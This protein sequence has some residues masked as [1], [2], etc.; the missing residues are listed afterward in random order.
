MIN[1]VTN[2]KDSLKKLDKDT[3]MCILEL[4]K[5]I[6]DKFKTLLAIKPQSVSPDITNLKKDLTD[7][8]DG[9]KDHVRGRNKAVME[10][11]KEL[12]NWVRRYIVDFA[13]V[14]FDDIEEVDYNE[15][16]LMSRLVP[17]PRFKQQWKKL[18][19]ITKSIWGDDWAR[20]VREDVF[21]AYL[22]NLSEQIIAMQI[23]YRDGDFNTMM[24]YYNRANKSMK[25][26]KHFLLSV[27]PKITNKYPGSS[28][29]DVLLSENCM[30]ILKM[31]EKTETDIEKL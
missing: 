5:K 25:M 1:G 15:E 9:V 6:D 21:V 23:C 11:V 26:L 7:R 28:E 31:A 29:V 16:K 20:K 13:V 19:E 14:G 8:I 22:G 2:F 18:I 3:R 10:E 17:P 27:F 12:T 24:F 30:E 4:D